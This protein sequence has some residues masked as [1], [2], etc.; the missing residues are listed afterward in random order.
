MQKGAAVTTQMLV[1]GYLKACQTYYEFRYNDRVLKNEEERWCDGVRRH[2]AVGSIIWGLPSE[3]PWC[4]TST[5]AYIPQL[6]RLTFL[7]LINLPRWGRRLTTLTNFGRSSPNQWLRVTSSPTS[8]KTLIQTLD[9][10]NSHFVIRRSHYFFCE[11]VESDQVGLRQCGEKSHILRY[12]QRER[13]H[14]KMGP[15]C[16]RNSSRRSRLGRIGRTSHWS[17]SVI[18]MRWF[19]R[20][21]N[22]LKLKKIKKSYK[23]CWQMWTNDARAW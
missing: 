9:V 12:F 17:H 3:R 4:E 11:K 1:G 8:L 19:S 7:R 20:R 13:C 14:E 21:S 16:D 2:G 5:L 23:I 18:E 15:T 10:L 6:R 22:N